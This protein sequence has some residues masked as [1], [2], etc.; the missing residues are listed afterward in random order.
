[1]KYILGPLTKDQKDIVDEALGER[2]HSMRQDT[3]LTPT[4]EQ[5]Q[6]ELPGFT[7]V[8]DDFKVVTS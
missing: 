1:M 8:P 7:P 6:T 2:W 5:E 3:E 4:G